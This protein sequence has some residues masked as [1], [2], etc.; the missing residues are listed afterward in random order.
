M[1]LAS[2]IGQTV[3]YLLLNELGIIFGSCCSLSAAF[4]TE[5]AGMTAAFSLFPTSNV[6]TGTSAHATWVLLVM[7]ARQHGEQVTRRKS[8]VHFYL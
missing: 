2:C 4:I 8:I 3:Q 1:R 6:T 5:F 7:P